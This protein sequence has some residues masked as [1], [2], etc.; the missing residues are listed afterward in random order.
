MKI[1]IISDTHLG[2]DKLV[3]YNNRPS[4]FTNKILKGLQTIKEDDI[5]IHLG[6][7]CM[8]QDTKWHT[9]FF[10]HSNARRHI[11]VKGNH[12][13][14]SNSWYYSHGWD[15]VCDNFTITAFSKKILFSHVPLMRLTHGIYD[16]NIHGHFHN[17]DHRRHELKF[18]IIKNKK[19]RLLAIEYTNYQPVS[20]QTFLGL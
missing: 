6:D 13:R 10:N 3:E 11:L 16:F 15:F 8:G 12:D 19:H 14:K 2:H 17:A 4:D 7:I 5:L 20:L 18:R 9:E 1:F